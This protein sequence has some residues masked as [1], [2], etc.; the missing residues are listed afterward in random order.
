MKATDK[1]IVI[2]LEATCW[3]GAIPADQASE[4]IEI[5]ICVLETSTGIISDNKGILIIP[6]Y[7]EVSSFC[8]AL[9][10]ITP[11]LLHQHGISFAAAC[12]MLQQEYSPGEYTWASYGAYDLKMMKAQCEQFKI[13]YPLSEN[14]INV[15]ELFAQERRLKKSVGMNK[16]LS[17][18]NIPLEGVHH[19]GVDDAKNIAKI[20]RWCLLKNN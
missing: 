19:R 8:T 1:L 16:A 17:I 2:D 5:G 9:T 15:K 4:I 20:L 10:T 6:K 12:D 11:E 3:D 18:L 13:T 7:S 14:H